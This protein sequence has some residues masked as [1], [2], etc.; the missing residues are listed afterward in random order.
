MDP[1]QPPPL[2]LASIVLANIILLAPVYLMVG[3]LLWY[4]SRV[5]AQHEQVYEWWTK[6]QIRTQP[7]VPFRGSSH[8]E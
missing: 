3:R 6:T 8:G 5:I 7:S 2:S 1:L 4:A